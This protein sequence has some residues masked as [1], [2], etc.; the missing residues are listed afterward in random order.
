[1]SSGW[2][3]STMATHENATVADLQGGGFA[4]LLS[5]IL[6]GAFAGSGFALLYFKDYGGGSDS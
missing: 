1:M 2:V 5:K 3:Y 6:S 4:L